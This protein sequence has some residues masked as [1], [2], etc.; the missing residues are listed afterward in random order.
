M[1]TA[2]KTPF[3]NNNNK[4]KKT[5]GQ[6]WLFCHFRFLRVVLVDGKPR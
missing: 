2:T 1:A 6:R 3:E 4:K 5:F